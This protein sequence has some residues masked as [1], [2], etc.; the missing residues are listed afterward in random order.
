MA[1]DN[2]NNK[3]KIRKDNAG[4]KEKLNKGWRAKASGKVRRNE[5]Q[6]KGIMW[7]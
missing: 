3:K 5:M 1:L 6:I 7:E 2:I 4:T